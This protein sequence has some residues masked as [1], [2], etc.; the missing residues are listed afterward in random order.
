MADYTDPKIIYEKN[1]EIMFVYFKINLALCS[2]YFSIIM[3]FIALI[4]F[5]KSVVIDKFTLIISISI[6]VE[7]MGKTSLLI[8]CLE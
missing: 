6:T 2:F 8:K 7:Y 1:M 4:I 5:H 3:L